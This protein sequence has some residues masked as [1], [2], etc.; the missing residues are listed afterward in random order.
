MQVQ[1]AAESLM[2]L[3][4]QTVLVKL[5]SDGSLL[6]PG[7]VGCAV[8]DLNSYIPD[9]LPT[10]KVIIPDIPCRCYMKYTLCSIKSSLE[11][12][13]AAAGW[14]WRGWWYFSGLHL[15]RSVCLRILA[16]QPFLAL[17]PPKDPLFCSL[18]AAF[19]LS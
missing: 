16:L 1:A 19:P 9:T 17:F 11:L 4:V 2:K 12:L 6:L 7:T 5:G 14:L 8:L 18:S 15:S 10:A 13:A 3:G